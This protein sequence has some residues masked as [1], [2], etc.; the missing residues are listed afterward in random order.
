[1]IL[2]HSLSKSSSGFHKKRR[3]NRF[4]PSLAFSFFLLLPIVSFATVDY[5]HSSHLSVSISEKVVTVSSPNYQQAGYFGTS[6]ATNGR[7]VVVGAPLE[8]VNGSGDAG[9]VYIFDSKTGSLIST[10]TSP[11]SQENGYFGNSVALSGTL[12]VIGAPQESVG[13][14]IQA[15]YVYIFNATTSK[16]MK[17]L[18]SPHPERIAYFGWSVDISHD[19]V[20]V[21]APLQNIN[22]SAYLFNATLGGVIRTLSYNEN[23]ELCFGSSVAVS[24]VFAVVGDPCFHNG[25]G[26]AYV[27]SVQKGKLTDNLDSSYGGNFGDGVTTSGK[28][29]VIGAP[30]QTVNGKGSEAGRVFIYNG[31]TSKMVENITSP[32]AQGAGDFGLSVVINGKMIVIGAPG[33]TANGYAYDGHAY[34]FSLGKNTFVK[35]LSSQNPEYYGY[36][37][38]SVGL[39]GTAIIVGAP[40]ETVNGDSV[41]GRAYIFVA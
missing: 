31:Q 18:R 3:A 33:E 12:L 41:A 39:G 38:Y 11:H 22:G 10:L 28:Y 19:I 4:L 24:A 9:R 35:T 17:T 15:G 21:G 37:G 7:I 16:L 6:V 8:R 32:N 23:D 13:K 1:L 26:H 14:V 29:V 36:F 25:N 27:F 5:Q 40:F 30:L 20:I 34:L 2:G